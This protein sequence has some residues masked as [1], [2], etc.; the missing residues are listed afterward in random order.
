MSLYSRLARSLGLTSSGRRGAAR[1]AAVVGLL[2]GGPPA[3]LALS[4]ILLSRD[5]I[6]DTPTYLVP[7]TLVATLWLVLG[8]GLVLFTERLVAQTRDLLAATEDDG[9]DMAQVR[10]AVREAEATHVPFLLFATAVAACALFFGRDSILQAYGLDSPWEQLCGAAV[11][12]A[13]ALTAGSGLWG[14]WLT[15]RVLVAATSSD[16]TWDPFEP[17][18]VP[19]VEALSGLGYFAGI[20][21]SAGSLQVPVLLRISSLLD[22]AARAAVFTALATIFV[23]GLAMFLLSNYLIAS[24]NRRQVE[25]Q[26]EPLAGPLAQG[27]ERLQ[28]GERMTAA[29]LTRLDLLLAYRQ[30]IRAETAAPYLTLSVSRATSTIVIPVAAAVV[31]LLATS[32]G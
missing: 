13:L 10:A 18:Q 26:L 29:E 24:M 4:W 22:G 30:A 15:V 28:V 31:P 16:V 8:P 32:A 6:A 3:V 5:E 27:L 17:R 1:D 2:A 25:A 23:A 14:M 12:A 7:A 20:A 21:L 19:G 11:V 9:W